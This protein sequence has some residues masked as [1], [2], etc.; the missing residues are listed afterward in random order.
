MEARFVRLTWD[1]ERV[2]VFT[3]YLMGSRIAEREKGTI[4]KKAVV[5]R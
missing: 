3:Q 5:S 1:L 4:V 2:V